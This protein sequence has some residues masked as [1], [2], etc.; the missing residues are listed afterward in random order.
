MKNNIILAKTLAIFVAFIGAVV[1]YGWIADIPLFK[2]IL[3][4]WVTMKFTTAMTFVI[5]G[6]SVYYVILFC[7]GKKKAQLFLPIINVAIVILRSIVLFSS[8]LGVR[9]SL[10]DL[11]VKEA[12][13]AVLTATPGRPSLGTMVCFLTIGFVRPTIG[14][15]YYNGRRGGGCTK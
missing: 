9:T 7:N 12:K 5:S 2:S 15:P 6:V 14:Q 10:E 13:N 4:T 11:F 3:P 1:M 8:W